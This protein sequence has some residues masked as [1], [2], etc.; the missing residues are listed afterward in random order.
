MLLNSEFQV[1]IFLPLKWICSFTNTAFELL[2][3]Y[4]P[5]TGH[6]LVSDFV[7]KTHCS[8]SAA[9]CLADIDVHWNCDLLVTSLLQDDLY[10]AGPL[11]KTLLVNNTIIR[12][13]SL[14]HVTPVFTIDLSFPC[15]ALFC[16]HI[17]VTL[18]TSHSPFNPDKDKLK[19]LDGYIHIHSLSLKFY[20]F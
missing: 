7:I 18:I 3:S 16:L 2:S 11:V 9:W 19:R 17:F 12:A 10:A 6:A 14:G 4:H 1:M 20:I 15:R 13:P 8:E 5:T